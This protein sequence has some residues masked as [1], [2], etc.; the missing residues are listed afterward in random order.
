M[1]QVDLTITGT[2]FPTIQLDGVARIAGAVSGIG[3]TR[4]YEGYKRFDDCDQFEQDVEALNPETAGFWSCWISSYDS[5]GDGE[6]V[7]LSINGELV[8]FVPKDR[9]TYMNQANELAFEVASALLTTGNW[10]S[11][12]VRPSGVGYRFDHIKHIETGGLCY[13]DFGSFGGGR[14]EFVGVCT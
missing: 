6:L 13:F 1:G 7:R 4:V 8:V 11:D 5:D 9:T 3:S 12:E 10:Q 14:I 2:S